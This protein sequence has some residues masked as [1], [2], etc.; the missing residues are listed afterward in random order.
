MWIDLVTTGASKSG[1]LTPLAREGRG[2]GLCRRQ[3]HSPKETIVK[4]HLFRFVAAATLVVGAASV[5]A[6]LSQAAPMHDPNSARQ[7]VTNPVHD[8]N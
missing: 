5:T 4:K 3:P 1:P 7:V 8:P 6:G 2:G